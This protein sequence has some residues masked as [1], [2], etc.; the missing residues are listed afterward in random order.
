MGSPVSLLLALLSQ[1]EG[2]GSSGSDGNGNDSGA[3][4]GMTRAACRE[5]SPGERFGEAETSRA[6]DGPPLPFDGGAARRR[7]AWLQIRSSGIRISL[8]PHVVDCPKGM[9]NGA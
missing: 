5:S 8:C 4:G 6:E 7:R 3:R 1:R 2:R 9:V